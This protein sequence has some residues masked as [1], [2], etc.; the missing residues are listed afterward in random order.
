MQETIVVFDTETTGLPPKGGYGKPH[1]DTDNWPRII[2]MAWSNYTMGGELISRHAYM[3][4]P[5][6]GGFMMDPDTVRF[7]MK[8]RGI[9]FVHDDNLSQKQ[10][11]EV[12]LLQLNAMLAENGKP[13]S[14]VLASFVKDAHKASVIVAHNLAFDTPIVKCEIFRVDSEAMGE[15]VDL[16]GVTSDIDY[17]PAKATHPG[18]KFVCTMLGM[19]RTFGRWP[20]LH[21]LHQ[22]L[23]GRKFDNAHD[24]GGD[25]DAAA[26]C[27]FEA[28]RQGHMS[29]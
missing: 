7:H 25:V 17:P 24:A 22:W 8:S 1:T 23:F 16:D 3:I 27:L 20:K 11:D 18:K 21:E 28:V 15:W 13:L 12:A 5:P 10:N 9:E 6:E 19:Q 4:T 29:L 26:A 2:Q 14:A